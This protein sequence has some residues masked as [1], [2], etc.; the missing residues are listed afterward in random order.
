MTSA[1]TIAV[2]SG[3]RRVLHAGYSVLSVTLAVKLSFDTPEIPVTVTRIGTGS[4][5][6]TT[7]GSSMSTCDAT[8]ESEPSRT[9]IS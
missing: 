8:V 7:A 4:L 6:D 9:T 2:V 1:M 5:P 3:V